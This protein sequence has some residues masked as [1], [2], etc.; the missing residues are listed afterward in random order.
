M[1][2]CPAHRPFVRIS[3]RDIDM[4]FLAHLNGRPTAIIN[5]NMTDIWQTVPSG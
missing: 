2:G 3:L 1:A 4:P 5:F